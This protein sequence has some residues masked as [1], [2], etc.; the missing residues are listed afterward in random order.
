MTLEE[1]YN[2]IR[3]VSNLK[4]EIDY[5]RD[6]K[7]KIYTIERPGAV[8]LVVLSTK[9]KL[10]KE[11]FI[12]MIEKKEEKLI[13]QYKICLK[14]LNDNGLKIE[15]S[16]PEDERKREE[17]KCIELFGEAPNFKE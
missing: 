13:K 3:E 4:K 15:S 6:L 7:N 5:L 10:L 8:Y 1:F 17:Q 14:K 2:V 16:L 11:D 9:H 12:E